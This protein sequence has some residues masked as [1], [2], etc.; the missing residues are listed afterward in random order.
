MLLLALVLPT[1]AGSVELDGVRWQSLQPPDAPEPEEAP[2][3]L[4]QS[5][6]VTLRPI[7]DG[8]AVSARWEVVAPGPG[9]LHVPVTDASSWVDTFR[10]SGEEATVTAE[11]D[12]RVLTVWVDRRGVLEMDGA[13]RGDASRGVTIDLLPAPRGTVSVDAGALQASVQALDGGVVVPGTDRFWTG[14]GHLQVRL[15]PPVQAH[16][17]H[18]LVTGQVGVGLTVGEAEA[19]GRARVQWSVRQGELHQA[20]LSVA[21][22]GDDLELTGA[23]LRSWHRSGDTVLVELQEPVD[24]VLRL[25]ATWTVVVPAGTEGELPLP[26]VR[27]LDTWRVESSVQLARDGEIEVIPELSGVEP[28]P[29]ASLPGWGQG[30]VEGTP[31]AAYSG[32][33]PKGRLSLLRFEPVP[34]PAVVVDVAQAQLAATEEGRLLVRS[35]YE[36][37]NER[38]SHLRIR[39]PDGLTLIGARVAGDTA[40]PVTDGTGGWLIPLVRSVETV[41]GLLTFPVEVTLLGEVGGKWSR[42]EE[43]TLPLPAVDAPVAAQ[44]VTV[45]LPP[46]YTS[47][48]EPGD[49]DVVDA[50]TEGDGITYGFGVG[51]VGAAE[52]DAVFQ[53]AVGDW[54]DNDFRGAQDKL[55]QLREMGADNDNVVRL[56]ANLDVVTGATPATEDDVTTRRVKDQAQARS[57]GEQ[58]RQRSVK[59]RAQREAERGNFAEAQVLY[60][61]ALDLSRDLG[62]LEQR[63]SVEY[64]SE[65]T[66]LEAE[67]SQLQTDV[68]QARVGNAGVEASALEGLDALG[69]SEAMVDSDSGATLCDL[70]DAEISGQLITP[71]GR[72]LDGALQFN[73]DD[74]IIIGGEESYEDEPMIAF[75]ADVPVDGAN[76]DEPSENWDEPD[77]YEPTVMASEVSHRRPRLRFPRIGGFAK[78][79]PPPDAPTP[80]PEEARPAGRPADASIQLMPTSSSST[81]EVTAAALSVVVPSTGEAVLYQTLLLPADTAPEVRVS[82]KLTRR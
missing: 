4:V 19:R 26:V 62:N 7:D 29:A 16:P 51:D 8:L 35:H 18:D 66:E 10:W 59:K 33:S 12:R 30:L 60:E 20:R 22:V 76:D 36:V 49:G 34:G 74:G 80:T 72:P 67:L 73:D 55:D 9:W 82:A 5:R 78:S 52:A 50:F 25:E 61:E 40:R 57:R 44:R 53:S 28:V 17:A 48:L 65:V 63:E 2:A 42:R 54:M 31:T 24:D 15:A 81:P 37:R 14:A 71:Q 32:A 56:Q 3:P 13:V 23:N 70:D 79:A 45:Y 77:V 6:A 75:G 47:R 1:L 58:E 46:E 11:G 38:A 64:R 69:S 68:V 27:P 43:R 39:P 41:E 21:G